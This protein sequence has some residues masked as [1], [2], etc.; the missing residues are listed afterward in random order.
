MVTQLPKLSRS[1]SLTFDTTVLSPDKIRVNVEVADKVATFDW[2]LPVS[3]SVASTGAK[4]KDETNLFFAAN[5]S[6]EGW[7]IGVE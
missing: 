1:C 2:C 6:T 3:E 7:K 4:T 5:F